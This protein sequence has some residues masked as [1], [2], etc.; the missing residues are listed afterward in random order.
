MGDARPISERVNRWQG[1]LK[2][3]PFLS[4]NTA[5]GGAVAHN[6][7]SVIIPCHHVVGSNGSLAG[8]VGGITKKIKLQ[9][10]KGVNTFVYFIPKS[11]RN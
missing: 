1:L 6:P 2:S 7:I 5:V 11:K 4:D 3:L 9:E 10:H 8:Y